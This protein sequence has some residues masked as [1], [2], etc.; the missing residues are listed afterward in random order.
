MENIIKETKEKGFVATY[1]GR[2]R[3][4]SGIHETNKSLYEQACRIAINTVAQ[5]TAAELMKMGMINLQRAIKEHRLDAHM[6]L[7]IHDELLISVPQ[8]QAQKSEKVIRETL[9]NVVSWT[10][11]LVVT[12]HV[13][14]DWKEVTK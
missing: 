5:G 3:Y 7:Q 12:T 6:I 13:G 2:R 14:N 9:E 1:F 11:P 8:E 10:V 4:I